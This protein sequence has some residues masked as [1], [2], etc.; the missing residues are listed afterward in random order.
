MP[1]NQRLAIRCYSGGIYSMSEPIYF[2]QD[3]PFPSTDFG[4]FPPELE[5]T[6]E[7]NAKGN[8][9]IKAIKHR[10]RAEEEAARDLKKDFRQLFADVT[11]ETT[12][13]TN[14]LPSRT[15]LAN[16]RIAAVT[17]RSA[18][19]SERSAH[20]SLKLQ[21]EVKELVS[22][23]SALAHAQELTNSL[24]RATDETLAKDMAD[25][26]RQMWK[27][28]RAALWIAIA[29]LVVALLSW[30]CPSPLGRPEDPPSAAGAHPASDPKLKEASTPLSSPP[31]KAPSESPTSL[32]STKKTEK[33]P[34]APLPPQIAPLGTEGAKPVTAPATPAN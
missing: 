5:F 17:T 26:N 1:E 21:G 18:I 10:K 12:H 13:P 6:A 24:N 3:E 9:R 20:E 15:L 29:A 19:E 22:K 14:D 7:E 8:E 27:I 34:P 4:G 30:L 32:D 16:R 11:D 31:G 33:A 25:L 23:L 28:A 2:T